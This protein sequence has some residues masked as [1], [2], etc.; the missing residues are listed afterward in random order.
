MMILPYSSTGRKVIFSN[1]SLETGTGKWIARLF[2]LSFF[3]E[4]FEH[5]RGSSAVFMSTL[6]SLKSPGFKYNVYK[7]W[8][9]YVRSCHVAQQ[10]C[11]VASNSMLLPCQTKFIACCISCH[12]YFLAFKMVLSKANF[13]Q[14]LK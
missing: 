8:Q 10:K 4:D 11:N 7:S 14:S 6:K 9:V 12:N 3:S 1:T 2:L 5:L 13:F